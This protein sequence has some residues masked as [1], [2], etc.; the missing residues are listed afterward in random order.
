MIASLEEILLM[1][2]IM[3]FATGSKTT[4]LLRKVLILSMPTKTE[5]AITARM[6]PKATVRVLVTATGTVK[7]TDN[8]ADEDPCG[9]KGWKN[10]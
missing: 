8:A 5:F 2:I 6:E 4:S 9:G 7:E 1:Q 10:R 3:V